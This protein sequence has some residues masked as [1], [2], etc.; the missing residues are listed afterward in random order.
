MAATKKPTELGP[1]GRRVAENVRALR[2]EQGVG[3]AQLADR[4]EELGRPLLSTGVSKLEA[5]TRRVDVDDL[6]A[7]S[8]ALGV[9]PSRLLLPVTDDDEDVELTPNRCAPGW[10]VWDWA[11]GRAPLPTLPEDEGLNTPDELADFRRLARPTA[12]RRH[13][14]HD[15]H[16]ALERVRQRVRRVLL[17]LHLRKAGDPLDVEAFRR[18]LDLTR[19]AVRSLEE[20]LE[21]VEEG[22]SRGE[23]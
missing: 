20:Q 4:L 5:G 17:G 23:R 12:A 10:S 3:Q 22:V 11:D 15:L 8:V 18:S 2:R 9:N 6:V 1:V 13:E 14:A 7:L 21:E 19:R 16:R